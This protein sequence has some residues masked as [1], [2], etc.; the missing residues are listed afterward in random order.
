M[1]RAAGRYGIRA[2]LWDK[3][4]SDDL[5]L[6]LLKNINL[7]CSEAK[8][9]KLIAVMIAIECRSWGIARH[10][11]NV[12][13][14]R[15]EPWGVSEP[16]K[17]FSDNDWEALKSGNLQ[18]RRILKLINYIHVLGVPWAVENPVSSILWWVPGFLK[19]AND[20]KVYVKMVDQC[21]FGT[22]WRKRT[23]LMFGNCDYADI[24]LCD[25]HVC[26]GRGLCSFSNKRHVELEGKRMTAQAQTYPPRL[27]QL[28][29][30][31]LCSNAVY[32]R[33]CSYSIN[34]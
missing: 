22:P 13:R 14:S 8:A 32:N 9:N 11:T 6:T 33:A 10:R 23:R 16:I 31:I 25:Q 21:A 34:S 30:K 27:S 28:L 24:S 17:P 29:A 26:S 20:P 15:A 4:I 1:G 12:I 2:R 7:L 3:S 19:L 18:A 5:D